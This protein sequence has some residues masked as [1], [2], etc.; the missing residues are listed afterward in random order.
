MNGFVVIEPR[1]GTIEFITRRLFC[2]GL[3]HLFDFRR[4]FSKVK[5]LDG[6]LRFPR[7]W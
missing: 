5:I 2:Q 3:L 6:F 1:N 4:E 7:G